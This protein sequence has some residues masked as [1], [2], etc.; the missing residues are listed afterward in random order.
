M[1][2]HDAFRHVAMDHVATMSTS[3]SVAD[4]QRLTAEREIA[5]AL[6]RNATQL[7]SHY[8]SEELSE[9]ALERIHQLASEAGK[10]RRNADSITEEEGHHSE[11]ESVES[12]P[13][14]SEHLVSDSHQTSLSVN[15]PSQQQSQE[16]A[17]AHPP[18]L[19]EMLAQKKHSD[20]DKKTSEDH[21]EEERDAELEITEKAPGDGGRRLAQ[22]AESSEEDLE[23]VKP[24]VH[25]ERTRT[26]PIEDEEM[27]KK[28]KKRVLTIDLD[29]VSEL[30]NID[31]K[32]DVSSSSDDNFETP[33][34]S[35]TSFSTN[36]F[37][38]LVEGSAVDNG[39]SKLKYLA[40][41][42]TG[43]E[44]APTVSQ[45]QED[46]SVLATAT[47][48]FRGDIGSMPPSHQ[49]RL[50][51]EDTDSVSASDYPQPG[52]PTCHQGTD[53]GVNTDSVEVFD[54]AS[55][56]PVVE[57]QQQSAN[58]DQ[59]ETSDHFTNT[60]IETEDRTMCTDRTETSEEATLV[61][62]VVQEKGANTELSAFELLKRVHSMEKLERLESETKIM[63][64]EL[65]EEKS[66]RMVGD[67]LVQM[68]QSEIV[69]LRQSNAS[70]TTS[71]LRLETEVASVKVRGKFTSHT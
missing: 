22:E 57:T 31:N 39:D 17:H 32:E 55:N 45:K 3:D 5:S 62:P 6:S 1:I 10:D 34:T 28:E 49:S 60:E 8:R 38:Q 16:Q 27:E 15:L 25:Q 12:E 51:A 59:M 9:R 26:L 69:E 48:P 4:D 2:S 52:T 13:P 50:G 66:K 35:P 53:C 37:T 36:L 67:S 61:K 33:P 24:A 11:P 44:E 23:N 54:Q 70:E 40:Q 41:P 65:N 68:L 7:W 71:R 46:L 56:T 47:D 42:Q 58:T 63:A 43:D 14:L 18:Q 64:L 19:L 30:A 21:E 29:T 20:S